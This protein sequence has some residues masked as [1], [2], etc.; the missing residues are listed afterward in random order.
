MKIAA[1]IE[2]SPNETRVAIS[3]ETAKAF[4]NLGFEVVIQRGAGKASSFSDEAYQS[5][6]ASLSDDAGIVATS[7]DI[8]LTVASPAHTII[9]E[10]K[11]ESILIGMLAQTKVKSHLPHYAKHIR[12]AFAMELVPRISR[13]QSMDVLSSQSNLAGYKAVI[14]AASHYGKVIPM[15]T[16]AAGSIK[17][18]KV[19]VL[20]AG[21]AGLQAIATAKRLG[22]V[23]SAFDVRPDAKEQVKSL[24]GVFIEVA[25]S[26]DASAQTAGGYAKEMSAD[27]KQKQSALIHETLRTQDIVICTA[28]IP[29]RPAPTL[30]T[31]EMV[32][33]MP[34]GSVI[35]DLAAATG[36]NCA[37]TQKG[38]VARVYRTTIIG[39]Q[40]M[41][42]R[43]AEDASRLYAKNLFQFV[44]LLINPET[45][46][47][48]IDQ[49]DDIIKGALLTYEGHVVHPLFK[50]ES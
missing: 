13:A 27:Y 44:K 18:A 38:K 11:K 45:K 50:T 48:Q 15:M 33:D 3:P 24:G 7:A 14:D 29:G 16:T 39:Y 25:S 8:L 30:I 23:V 34:K 37:L 1:I 6:G 43:L 10:L 12:A 22:A 20:G 36:G 9:S 4:V 31:E 42:G 21:V 5:A 26:E 41:P 35:V 19:L 2:K 28:L 17:P 40:N 47:L 49:A 46:T 32:R